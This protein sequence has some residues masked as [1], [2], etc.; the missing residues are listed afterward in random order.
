MPKPAST[1]TLSLT[2]SSCAMRRV[3]SGTPPS[4]LTITSTLRPATV[5]PFCAMPELD[6]RLDLLAG[7]RR[8]ARHGQDEA[9]LERRAL[10]VR[11]G[12][13]RR[14]RGAA[15][16][17]TGATK[18]VG[19]V[20]MRIARASRFG[21]SP[22]RA[23]GAA[24]RTFVQRRARSARLCI[25]RPPFAAPRSATRARHDDPQPAALSRRPRRQ[26][27]A[28]EVPARGARADR[29]SG[30]I[31]AASSCAPSRTTRSPRSSSSRRTSACKSITDGEFRRT[32][33]HID[34]L[35]QLG[36]VQDRHPGDDHAS[37]TAARS[38][39]RR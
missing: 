5:L 32:Y 29:R 7:R 3:A 27:P 14:S 28:P 11:A 31:D 8:L 4:S 9:D 16:A 34:F 6:R 17:A 19:G 38:S 2:T 15:S 20:C 39:R 23:A 18:C 10:R 22:A 1:S 30:E 21:D 36:G 37:P 24:M 33:F 26:L 13:E 25:A 12:A 35:E